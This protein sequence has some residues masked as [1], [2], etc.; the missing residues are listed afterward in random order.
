MHVASRAGAQ[1]SYMSMCVCAYIE[2]YEWEPPEE[3]KVRLGRMEME[4]NRK[5]KNSNCESVITFLRASSIA[6]RTHTHTH[7]V[8]ISRVLACFS[9]PCF[10]IDAMIVDHSYSFVSVRCHRPA[11]FIRRKAG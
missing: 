11:G 7:L 9:L 4:L 2:V 1:R 5:A 6:F 3:M 8:F 10:L